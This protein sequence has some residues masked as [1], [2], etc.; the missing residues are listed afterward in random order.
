MFDGARADAG[1]RLPEANGM[2]IPSWR[3]GVSS[4]MFRWF[5]FSIGKRKTW[6]DRPVH[7]ITLIVGTAPQHAAGSDWTWGGHGGKK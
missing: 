1:Q 6:E 5:F 4:N 2:I 7:S 3:L